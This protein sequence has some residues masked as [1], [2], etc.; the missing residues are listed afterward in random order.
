MC[1]A[2]QKKTGD[3]LEGKGGEAL[4][5]KKDESHTQTHT[6]AHMRML[7]TQLIIKPGIFLKNGRKEGRG[8][9]RKRRSPSRTRKLPFIRLFALA[10]THTYT[11]TEIERERD[12]EEAK[13]EGK[14]KITRPTRMALR[15]KPTIGTLKTTLDKRN[16]RSQ[17]K[18][19][20]KERQTPTHTHTHNSSN[21]QIKNE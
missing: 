19:I 15:R 16:D 21:K 3:P 13:G 17:T 4:N 20:G 10:H 9:S 11:H 7:F 6:N 18:E 14:E 12:T 5:N 8:K 2:A 1:S